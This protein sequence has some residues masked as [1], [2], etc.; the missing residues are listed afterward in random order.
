MISSVRRPFWES[1]VNAAPPKEIMYQPRHEEESAAAR[2][3]EQVEAHPD[4]DECDYPGH[5][6]SSEDCATDG[7]PKQCIANLR[8]YHGYEK[9]AEPSAEKPSAAELVLYPRGNPGWVVSHRIPFHEI[10][11]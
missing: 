8:Q 9:A 4:D 2:A 10:A 7:P 11:V 5:G 3:S 1:A 6:K